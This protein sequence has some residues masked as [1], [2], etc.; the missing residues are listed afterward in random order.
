MND[1]LPNATHQAAH[2]LFDEALDRSA[3]TRAIG[4][5]ACL[6]TGYREPASEA[7]DASAT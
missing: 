1:E 5:S 3:G 6:F 2:P 7:P 4:A